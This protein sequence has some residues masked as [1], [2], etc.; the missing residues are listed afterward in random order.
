MLFD[1]V[2]RVGSRGFGEVVSWPRHVPLK[3]EVAPRHE[4]TKIGIESN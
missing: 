3:P 4:S 1:R 2:Q